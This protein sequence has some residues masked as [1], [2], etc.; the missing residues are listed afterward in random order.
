MFP[1]FGQS[2]GRNA[3]I[4]IV[5]IIALCA[6][7][8]A[9][10]QETDRVRLFE[11]EPYDLLKVKGNDKLLRIKLLPP[12]E[13]R[14][15]DAKRRTGHLV[16]RLMDAPDAKYEVAWAS[17]EKIDFFEQRILAEALE[18]VGKGKHDDAYDYFRFLQDEYP[19]TPNLTPA[20]EQYLWSEAEHWRTAGNRDVE[21]AM[22]VELA[23][24]SPNFAGLEPALTD[25]TTALIGQA[26]EK[27]DFVTARAFARSIRERYPKAA[28][29]LAGEEQLQ[30]LAA[31][32]VAAGREHLA[33]ERMAEAYDQAGLALQIWPDA[34]S[35]KQLTVDLATVHPRVVV[36]VTA[37][38]LENL[39]G[40]FADRGAMRRQQLTGT[41]LVQFQGY[42]PDGALYAS[43]LA[44]IEETDLGR[45]LLITLRPGNRWSADGAELTGA[46]VARRL[47]ELG[48][49]NGPD[50][51]PELAELLEAVSVQDVYRVECDLTRQ[52]VKPIALLA[53]ELTP[54]YGEQGTLA[55]FQAGA[56]TAPDHRYVFNP[57]QPPSPGAPREIVERPF[58]SD[59][60]ALAAFR[61]GEI[62]VLDR[63][64]PAQVK[65][66]EGDPDVVVVPYATPTLHVLV[67]NRNRPLLADRNFRRALVYGTNRQV[68][69][70][71][72]IWRGPVPTGSRVVSGPFPAGA[73]ADDPRG[74]AYNIQVQPRPYDAR[75]ALTLIGVARL[76]QAGPSDVNQESSGAEPDAEAVEKQAAEAR[77][78][79]PLR[80]AF[81]ATDIARATAASIARQWKPLGIEVELFEFGDDITEAELDRCDLVY[82]ELIIREPVVEARR[83]LG[84]D[85]ALGSSNA[86]LDLTLARLVAAD[87]SRDSRDRLRELHRLAAE[88]V[89]LIPLW[90]LVDHF[91]YH[92]S[93][94]GVG[95]APATLYQ[96]LRDWRPTPRLPGGRP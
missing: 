17:I 36:G 12:V 25:A 34:E 87:N 77:K 27:K 75:L 3:M 2:R 5:A 92:R 81:P 61:R 49:S 55:S 96:N 24:R 43:S 32:A 62:S 1:A 76:S 11:R 58:G 89:T 33:A 46:D 93:L 84:S 88:D 64:N 10:G 59:A 74:Y 63:V 44:T 23:T 85:G 60:E 28:A 68:M 13:R 69:L 40:G 51:R 47:L 82:R 56:A 7:A 29:A 73:S 19:D 54:G 48:R 42:G 50:A 14:G 45:R 31:A 65:E 86:Y 71:K 4:A 30:K 70:E 83:L 53:F 80:L 6:G 39:A 66:L 90:Q 18:L 37:P 41:P 35:A 78:P 79:I 91:A 95:D 72:M 57:R 20:L 67:P 15:S 8:P 9:K 21:V 52:F 26:I 38:S 22:L 94:A 16:I